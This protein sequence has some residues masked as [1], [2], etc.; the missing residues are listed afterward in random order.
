M[1]GVFARERALMVNQW[2]LLLVLVTLIA[3]PVRS[4]AVV[5]VLM[6]Y[7]IGY[8]VAN[9]A[10]LAVTRFD[11]AVVGLLSLLLL[12]RV[13]IFVIDDY[14]S[15]YLSP[16]FHMVAVVPIYLM[17]R[18]LLAPVDLRHVRGF[19]EWGVIAGT[20]GALAVALYQTQ[21][22]GSY[23]A[24]GFLFSINLG[25]L[26]CAMAFLAASLV[27]GSHRKAWLLAAALAG[28]VTC[29]LTLARGAIL[30]VP[31]LLVL[32]L[33]LNADRLG[34][35]AI[36]ASF[37]AL[38]TL[39]LISYAT[40]PAVE[41]RVDYSIAEFTNITEGNIGAA[42][43]SGGRLQL[44]TAASH[45]FLERP[46]VGLSYDEREAQ[47]A[48]LVEQ[49]VLTDWVL[50]VQRGHAH[51]QY[52][53]M[54]ATGGVLGLIALLGYLVAPAIYHWRLYRRD[55]GNPWAQAALVFTVGFAIYGLTEA[56]IHHEMMTTF[57]AYMQ[58]L[59]L[60]LALCHR[61]GVSVDRR[62]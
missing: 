30:A 10:T 41:R 6:L 62:T 26:S 12:S 43:S 1:S 23:R 54:A 34:W 58:V 4:H 8:L 3:T 5:A 49:G 38:V 61:H 22:L 21:V 27:R 13:P 50:G 2:A 55:R 16:G 44:W 24:D 36:T 19:M 40:L 45:A 25:Y 14:S 15:R 33:L 42:V 51:S 9:R 56:A 20:L 28:V 37:V 18:H 53:E 32:L 39:A 17:L 52:F 31:L 46:L 59:L 7:A 57:Y 29:L 47:I 11:W 48:E 60:A 35:K